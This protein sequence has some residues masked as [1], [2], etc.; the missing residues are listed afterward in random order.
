MLRQLSGGERLAGE[1]FYATCA[2]GAPSQVPRAIYFVF[3]VL[4]FTLRHVI[5]IAFRSN[6]IKIP[7]TSHSASRR[8]IDDQL[9]S[10]QMRV[11][12]CNNE[13]ALNALPVINATI[14]LAC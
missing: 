9:R 14:L 4:R 7:H 3:C 1:T 12:H 5:L 2:V 13:S 10:S 11:S 6:P 8:T